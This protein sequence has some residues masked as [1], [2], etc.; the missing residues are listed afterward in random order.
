ML[1]FVSP[2]KLTHVTLALYGA[3]I[4]LLMYPQRR[5]QSTHDQTLAVVH[6]QPRTIL[7]DTLESRRIFVASLPHS[8]IRM[9]WLICLDQTSTGKAWLYSAASLIELHSTRPF[10][11]EHLV[12]ESLK[13]KRGETYVLDLAI[14]GDRVRGSIKITFDSPEFSTQTFPLDGSELDREIQGA[15]ASFGSRF[16]NVKFIEE[17]G[18]TV[19]AE[20]LLFKTRG[21]DA[22]LITFFESY[23]GEPNFVSFELVDLCM[24]AKRKY[25]FNLKLGNGQTG[26][27]IATLTGECIRLERIDLKQIMDSSQLPLLKRKA[28]F[29]P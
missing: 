8:D 22:G 9:G 27:Y 10:Q 15:N 13:L 17:S 14:Q 7:S 2:R 26:N 16:S 11:S 29:L 1:V 4:A 24:P 12:F 5:V 21:K 28:M 6:T 3:L 19:G 18:D 25:A 20:L 23:W